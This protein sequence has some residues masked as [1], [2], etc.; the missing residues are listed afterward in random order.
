MQIGL[1]NFQLQY[2]LTPI[3]KQDFRG[4]LEKVSAI[5]YEGVEYM[6]SFHCGESLR[7]FRKGFDDYGLKVIGSHVQMNHLRDELEQ[8]IEENLMLGSN[9]ITCAYNAFE[10]M[11]KVEAAAEFYNTVGQKCKQNGLQFCYHNHF[12]EFV[13]IDGRYA[14]DLMYEKTDRNWVQ[15]QIDVYMLLNLG[16]DVNSYVLKYKDRCPLLH[17]KDMGGLDKGVVSVGTGELDLPSLVDTAKTIGTEWLIIE[18]GEEILVE[19]PFEVLKE[20]YENLKKYTGSM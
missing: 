15:A 9:Y 8:V 4:T 16:I 19:K 17:V 20:S 11:E 5:G 3:M 2:N 7:D 1:M 10:T 14:L 13:E 12:K 6:Y 18:L